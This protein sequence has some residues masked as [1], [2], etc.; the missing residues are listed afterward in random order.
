MDTLKR[1]SELAKERDI[2]LSKLATMC[3]MHSATLY[4]AVQRGSQLSIDTI[5]RICK[6]LDISLAEFFTEPGSKAPSSTA[7]TQELSPEDMLILRKLIDEQ[8]GKE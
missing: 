6:G 4:S 5:E 8:K 1:V 3:G 7:S 2:S